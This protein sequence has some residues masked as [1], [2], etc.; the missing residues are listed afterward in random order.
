MRRVGRRGDESIGA[1]A[2]A[3]PPGLSWRLPLIKE[4]MLK[5]LLVGAL[6]ALAAPALLVSPAGADVPNKQPKLSAECPGQPGKSARL[7]YTIRKQQVTKLAIDNPCSSYVMFW[8]QGTYAS[9]KARDEWFAAPGSHFNWGKK[10]IAQYN[11][12]GITPGIYGWMAEGKCGGPTTRMIVSRY[13]NFSP[14]MNP[15]YPDETC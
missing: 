7:W 5:K 2:A 9:G 1:V 12:R 3:G 15:D 11:V 13:D 4:Q 14:L 6:L 10:R 8:T